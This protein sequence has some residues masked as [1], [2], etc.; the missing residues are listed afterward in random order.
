MRDFSKKLSSLSMLAIMLLVV[1]CKSKVEDKTNQ[2][3][4]MIAV[5]RLSKI[6]DLPIT[7]DGLDTSPIIKRKVSVQAC[8]VDRAT[9]KQLKN[10]Q[11]EITGLGSRSL[12]HNGCTTWE[13]QYHVD[14]SGALQCHTEKKDI[15]VTGTDFQATLTYQY[16]SQSAQFYDLSKT[17]GCSE[18]QANLRANVAGESNLI[19]DTIYLTSG[20]TPEKIRSDVRHQKYTTKLKSCLR[21]RFNNRPVANTVIN[22]RIDDINKEAQPVVLNNVLTD[23]QGCFEQNYV[24]EF[25]QF[26]YSH[27]M[28]KGLTVNIPFGT[29]E[30]E[31]VSRIFYVNPWEQERNLFGMDS[32][33]GTPEE[34]PK[35]V[36]NKFHIDGVMYIQ[37]GN[38]IENFKV[39]NYLGLTMSKSY[40]IVLN[41][42][43]DRGHLFNNKATRYVKVRDG[44]FKLSF[45]VLAP[46]KADIELTHE[47]FHKFEYITG[48]ESVV[49]VK[50]GTINSLINLPIK[51]T[52]LPRLAT[53]TVSV[54]KLE[55]LSDTGLRETLVTGFFKAK[56][57]WIK[58]NVIQSD[59][60]QT[61]EQ[62]LA[63][64]YDANTHSRLVNEVNRTLADGTFDK[65][66][67]DQVENLES[68]DGPSITQEESDQLVENIRSHEYKKAMEKMFGNITNYTQNNIYGDPEAFIDDSPMAIYKRHLRKIY[69]G[70]VI[71]DNSKEATNKRSPIDL[72]DASIDEMY[73]NGFRTPEKVQSVL[74]NICRM[75]F[76]KK[77]Y[78]SGF[79]E[80]L[81]F[82]K[83][84]E[85]KNCLKKPNKYWRIRSVVHTDKV[86][87]TTPLYSNGFSLSMGTRFSTGYSEAHTEYVSK[88]VG[89]DAGFKLPLGEWFGAGLKLFDI[90]YTWSDSESASEALS[91]DV[92]TSKYI[93]VEKFNV[94]VEGSFNRCVLLEGKDYHPVEMAYVAGANSYSI[95][96][97]G[98]N[99]MRKKMKLNY[100]LCSSS[101]P[102]I[103]TESWYYMQSDVSTSSLLRDAYGPTE[104]K[105]IK[106][107]R[108]LKNYKEFENLFRDKTKVYLIEED[109]ASDTPDIKLFENWGHLIKTEE[110]P[111]VVNS[112]LIR[113][114]EGSFP[115]TIEK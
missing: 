55:P 25:E 31:T 69:N 57:T 38:D 72:T 51:L 26:K 7:A 3:N 59:I 90:S 104:I 67:L 70:Q 42:K 108:G 65:E 71:E 92:S 56:I 101:R 2:S 1:S 86:K 115:G 87:N 35:K 49:N 105:L 47:N 14:V 24:S 79:R 23:A 11:V 78:A 88:R 68:L 19:L 75:A 113:N 6:N 62:E 89:V 4:Q 16:D 37:I 32:K 53:R 50:D 73:E 82:S 54:F 97:N 45:I 52:D 34:N 29:F 41:P 12:D 112:L 48:A 15:K 13:H 100:Y 106:V 58:T 77:Q 110:A 114:V 36:F 103:M 98:V 64:R 28:T 17:S 99:Q 85:Y 22:I 43:I 107:V 30:G 18:K 8:L 60:L 80:M 39:N 44:K 76:P 61:S 46:N 66:K 27:W 5:D 83:D 84:K 33:N 74:Q 109:Y 94:R 96:V 102:E 63:D 111:S 9:N 91:D 10:T 93:Q 81:D 40:Q 95:M 21:S 20:G